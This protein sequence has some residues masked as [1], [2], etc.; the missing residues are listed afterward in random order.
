MYRKAVIDL[1]SNSFH[2]IV[3]EIKEESSFKV[4]ERVYRLNQ[5]GGCI[6]DHGYLPANHVADAAS[7]VNEL[8]DTAL[9]SGADSVNVFATRVF[10]CCLNADELVSLIESQ[11][12]VHVD[13]LSERDEAECIFRAVKNTYPEKPDFVIIDIG[14]GS[15]EIIHVKSG[16]MVWYSSV[17]FGTNAW[18][19]YYGSSKS[20]QTADEQVR[21]S[22]SS[23]LGYLRAVEVE[24]VFGTSGFLNLITEELRTGKNVVDKDF[25]GR[26]LSLGQIETFSCSEF[27]DDLSRE[28]RLMCSGSRIIAPLMRSLYKK[29][30]IVSSVSTR[31]GYLLKLLSQ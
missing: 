8:K 31:E 28:K 7:I 27:A 9:K 17:P 3:Y 4:V 24:C 1:G 16:D 25:K 22:F 19:G 15:S 18:A 12:G 13:V 26:V 2:L 6:D 23:A 20:L 21:S 30:I 29:N 14:G 5:L 11:A 10:R